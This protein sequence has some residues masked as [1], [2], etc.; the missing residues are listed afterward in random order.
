MINEL[1][2]LL[3][4]YEDYPFSSSFQN[5]S[6]FSISINNQYAKFNKN[7][8]VGFFFQWNNPKCIFLLLGER[9]G[10]TSFRKKLK[11]AR[12]TFDT[13]GTYRIVA[14]GKYCQ[15]EKKVEVRVISKY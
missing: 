8:S 3:K 10:S 4:T 11:L 13:A 9:Y 2:L 15:F 1:L 5:L 6:P 7:F 14:R 12:I